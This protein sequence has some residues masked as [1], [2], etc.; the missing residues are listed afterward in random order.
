MASTSTERVRR[1]R[2]RKKW[3]E[4][5]FAGKPPPLSELPPSGEEWQ[6][7]A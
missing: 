3:L 4:L 1:H 7:G 6:V 5:Q 2:E